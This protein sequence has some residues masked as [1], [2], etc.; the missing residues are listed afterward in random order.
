MLCAG[1]PKYYFHVAQLFEKYKHYH[2]VVAFTALARTALSEK[3]IEV[4][5]LCSFVF[6]LINETNH[7]VH[8]PINLYVQ[9]SCPDNLMPVYKSKCTTKPTS[10]S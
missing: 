4:R 6:S 8:R 5:L 1:L 7:S 3:P 9:T 2:E 10:R